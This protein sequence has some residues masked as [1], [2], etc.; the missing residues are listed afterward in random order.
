MHWLCE[1][2]GEVVAIDIDPRFVSTQGRS[3]LAIRRADVAA[4][5]IEQ[6]TYDLVHARCVLM[7][8]PQRTQALANLWRALKPGGWLLI[9]E[10]NFSTALPSESTGNAADALRSVFEATLALYTSIGADGLLG[11]RLPPLLARLGLVG[12]E[13]KRSLRLPG[14]GRAG[15]KSGAWPLNTSL[16]VCWQ[17]DEPALPTW[18]LSWGQWMIQAPGSRIM[19]WQRRGSSA[20]LHNSAPTWGTLHGASMQTAFVPTVPNP[21]LT[22][23]LSWRTRV[24]DRPRRVA[25]ALGEQ[26]WERAL[27]SP[28]FGPVRGGCMP[29]CWISA[30]GSSSLTIIG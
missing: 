5:A 14:V 19:P 22:A 25:H 29:S 9:E 21:N 28:S 24:S 16:P 3:N 17:R 12:L 1:H 4:D 20:H 6:E 23:L 8:V 27:Q 15:R 26:S 18:V 30:F 13:Q 2:V 11:R 7:H 10:P